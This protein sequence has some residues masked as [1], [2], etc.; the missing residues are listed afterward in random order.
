MSL[1]LQRSETPAWADLW[2]SVRDRLRAELGQGVFDTWI[3]RGMQLAAMQTDE[4]AEVLVETI[5]VLL[6]NPGINLDY[7]VI[8]P[9]DPVERPRRLAELRDLIRREAIAVRRSVDPGFVP[10][11][12]NAA[13]PYVG[14]SPRFE[15]K[16]INEVLV[17]EGQKV[18]K[19]Q[20]LLRLDPTEARSRLAATTAELRL[21][22]ARGARLTELLKQPQ[23]KPLPVEE[24]V[25]AIF[26]GVR[27]YLDKI[28]VGRVGAF[29]AQ[30]DRKSTRLNSSHVKRSRMP[31]SA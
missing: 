29:E 26:A 17:R 31:S 24:Q 7:F 9:V 12:P 22:L 16:P 28:E 4:V 6:R 2:G 10:P 1:P 11:A 30:L 18:A 25:V 8:R 21:A 15:L 27:G 19:G 13:E 5:E 23:F 3:A 14:L 20:V